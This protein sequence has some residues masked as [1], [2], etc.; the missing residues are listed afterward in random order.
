VAAGSDPG[1][2]L[3]LGYAD[4]NESFAHLLPRSRWQGDEIGGTEPTSVFILLAGDVTRVQDGFEVEDFQ[5]VAW[6]LARPI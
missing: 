2:R 1:M 3:R 6:G 4:Q 5:H